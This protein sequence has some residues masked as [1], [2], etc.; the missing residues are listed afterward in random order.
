MMIG[1]TFSMVRDWGNRAGGTGMAWTQGATCTLCATVGQLMV[2]MI[3]GLP[4]MVGDWG[5]RTGLER[6]LCTQGA[7]CAWSA[8]VGLLVIAASLYLSH[9]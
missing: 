6:W 5:N 8:A 2:K 1:L 7:T 3:I 4:S 9:Y